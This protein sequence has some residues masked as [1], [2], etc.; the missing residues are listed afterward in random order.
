GDLTQVIAHVGGGAP[1]RVTETYYEWRDRPVATKDGVQQSEDTTT[2]RPLVFTT[3]DN[4]DEPIEQ[5]QYDGDGVTITTSGGVPQP[6]AASLLR[7][8]TVSSYD[9]QGRVYRTQLYGVDPTSGAVSSTALTTNDYYDHRGDLIAEAQPG[10]L[11][12]KSQYDGA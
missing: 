2:F 12:T 10:G 11:W 7:A 9:D 5:Q 3:Y 6:P 4:L 8:Q 1:D